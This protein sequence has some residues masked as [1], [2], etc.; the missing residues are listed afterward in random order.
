[1]YSRSEHPTLA[2]GVM[3]VK[4]PQRP[5][6]AYVQRHVLNALQLPEL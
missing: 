6:V 3:P 1:V 2:R 5:E 4:N